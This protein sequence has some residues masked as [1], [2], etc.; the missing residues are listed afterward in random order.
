MVIDVVLSNLLNLVWNLLWTHYEIEE[1]GVQTGG[2]IYTWDIWNFILSV[3]AIAHQVH[4]NTHN[5]MVQR[6]VFR[7]PCTSL[8]YGCKLEWGFKIF[9]VCFVLLWF[10][11]AVCGILPY[12]V[13]DK[14]GW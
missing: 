5:P 9:G 8:L 3:P 6:S 1:G 7:E 10:F 2:N 4:Y 11:C 12:I 14:W 13:K